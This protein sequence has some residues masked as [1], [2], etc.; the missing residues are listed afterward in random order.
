M[1]GPFPAG[2]TLT[3]HQ[4]LCRD[5]H[6]R[7]GIETNDISYDF[8]IGC[9]PITARLLCRKRELPVS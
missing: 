3:L 8:G 2:S 5:G 9:A 4:E 6:A 7:Q 1:D